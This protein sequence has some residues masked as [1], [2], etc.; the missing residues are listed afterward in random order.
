[1]LMLKL[2]QSVPPPHLSP[3]L[4]PCSCCCPPC[5]GAPAAPRL[6]CLKEKGWKGLLTTGFCSLLKCVA[7][8]LGFAHLPNP[9]K[10]H[11]HTA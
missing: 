4:W 10:N 7:F 5:T 9:C 1:M 8:H 11:L 2:P 3:L 6:A